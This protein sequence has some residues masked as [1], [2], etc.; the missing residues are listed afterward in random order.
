MNQNVGL[1][2]Y[3]SSSCIAASLGRIKKRRRVTGIQN[4]IQKKYWEGFKK[5]NETAKQAVHVIVA[6]VYIL[7]VVN[8]F[9]TCSQI[10]A[11]D[12]RRM[13]FMKLD[14]KGVEAAKIKSPT[15]KPTS[16]QT[17]SGPLVMNP[18]N[19]PIPL[20]FLRHSIIISMATPMQSIAMMIP[21]APAVA[22]RIFPP[23]RR[24]LPIKKTRTNT[25]AIRSS[26]PRDFVINFF[27]SWL[28][29]DEGGWNQCLFLVMKSAILTLLINS[30][31]RIWSS[32]FS[33]GI[34]RIP[35]IQVLLGAAMTST[36]ST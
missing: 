17:A 34:I 19:V 24:E 12:R 35:S 31:L 3:S 13:G 8:V 16:R 29:D 4:N 11:A 10:T 22:D 1:N 21:A 15:S 30:A 14:P 36:S 25:Q 7:F 2:E 18:V 23:K 27:K 28:K 33:A 5:K 32:T 6:A 9:V 20:L 26:R